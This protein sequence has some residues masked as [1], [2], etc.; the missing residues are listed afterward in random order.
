M[1]D[2]HTILETDILW[3][4][5]FLLVNSLV[6]LIPKK[7]LCFNLHSPYLFMFN[8]S[9]ESK[10]FCLRSR[11]QVGSNLMSFGPALNTLLISFISWFLIELQALFFHICSSFNT[12]KFLKFSPNVICSL[13]IV[14]LIYKSK[15]RTVTPKVSYFI[16]EMSF[17]SAYVKAILKDPYNRSII[18][19]VSKTNIFAYIF[20]APFLLYL[21]F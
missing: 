6:L 5:G 14:I 3:I 11:L 21:S 20:I 17:V 13:A 8:L 15:P 16:W 4:R 7:L 2:E 10:M 12:P 9:L 19:Y 18:V 1:I